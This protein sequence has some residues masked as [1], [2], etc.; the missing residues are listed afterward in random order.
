MP[1]RIVNRTHPDA[2]IL[3]AHYCAS[4]LCQLRGLMF[5]SALAEDE[6]L[7]LVQSA[8]SRLNA[9]I[10]MFGM[11]FDLTIVW[12]DTQKRVVDV[13]I[14]RRWP[15]FYFPCAPARYVLETGTQH[16]AHFRPGDTLDFED[17]PN[18]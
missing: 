6:G 18:R 7:L 15:P 5:R 8:E 14:A 4:F 2:P 9:A 10:H 13:Q 16:F 12:I 11:A 1:V 17:L 3:R